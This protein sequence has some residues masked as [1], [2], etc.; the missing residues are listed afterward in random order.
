MPFTDECTER[1]GSVVVST[2]LSSHASSEMGTNYVEKLERI[3][4]RQK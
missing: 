3:V 4:Y 2:Q 1:P